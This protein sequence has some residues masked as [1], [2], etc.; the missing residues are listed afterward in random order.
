MGMLHI[1]CGLTAT[2][3]LKRPCSL[4]FDNVNNATLAQVLTGLL[5]RSFSYVPR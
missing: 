5:Q 4:A 3:G 1:Y 2:A